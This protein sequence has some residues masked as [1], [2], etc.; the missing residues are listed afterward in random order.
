MKKNPESSAEEEKILKKSIFYSFSLYVRMGIK[1][2][3]GLF[4]AKFLGPSLYGLRNI[5][6]LTIEYESY[7]DLG[8]LSAINRQIPYYRGR[9]EL[10]NERLA[11]GSVFG[12]NFI[13][14][15][16]VGILLI[17]VSF[18]LKRAQ[19]DQKYTDFAFFLGLMIITNKIKYFYTTKLKYDNKFYLLSMAEMLYG[20]SAAALCVSLTYFYSFRGLLSGLFTADIVFIG[21]VLLKIKEIPSFRISFPLLRELIKIGFPIMVVGFLLTLMR[22]ADRI[23]ILAMLS[24]EALGYFSVATIATSII[25][26]VP[27]AIRQVTL[28]PMMEKLGR[29][30]D[31]F[32]IKNYLIDPTVLIACSL[33]FLLLP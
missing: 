4:I 29:T 27:S 32:R 26:T 28:P 16:C 6:D 24:E 21:Y 3:Q 1:I 23:V 7:S 22:S 18:Y 19:W 31:I 15:L 30:N 14:A 33:P 20:F 5:F 25:V 9:D 13:Y 2:L 10:G 8:S 12:I 17:G 11:E